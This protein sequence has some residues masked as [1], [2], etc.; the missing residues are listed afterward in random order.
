[1]FGGAGDPG[2]A[3][4]GFWAI[5]SADAPEK[6]DFTRV[7]NELVEDAGGAVEAVGSGAGGGGSPLD[8]PRSDEQPASAAAAATQ[9]TRGSAQCREE[10][11]ASVPRK[12]TQRQGTVR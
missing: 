5:R 3:T 11:C 2:A 7:V 10:P 4:A 9:A 12:D 8:S 6:N 1:M